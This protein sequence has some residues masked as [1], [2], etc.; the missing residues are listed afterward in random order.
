MGTGTERAAEEIRE[1]VPDARVLRMDRDTT[2]EKGAHGRI[3]GR[4]ERGE[5]DVL[6]GTQM[7]AKGLDFPRVTLV[8]VILADVGLHFPDFRAAEHTFSLLAQVA[9]RAGRR[10]A[11]GRVLVQTFCADHWAIGCAARHD[12]EG[13]FATEI[14]SR[15]RDGYPP[16]M[17]LAN[18]VAA[19]EDAFVAEAAI[20]AMAEAAQAL[21]PNGA[22]VLGPAACPIMKLRGKAR[23][24]VELFAPADDVQQWVRTVLGRLSTEARSLLVVDM[25][26]LSLM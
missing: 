3:L 14:E 7:I 1:F 18:I 26:P 2:T 10:A 21:Q 17:R 12:F 8:G 15:R 22:R 20:E 19:H 16:F 4:F 23:F 11:E 13:F 6:I 5:A 24:H 9:G 25:D